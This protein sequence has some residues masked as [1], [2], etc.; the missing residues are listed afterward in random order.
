LFPFIDR[1][2]IE[3][4]TEQITE[5]NKIHITR[6]MTTTD[7]CQLKLTTEMNPVKGEGTKDEEIDKRGRRVIVQAVVS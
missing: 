7:N 2:V 5:K 3:A 1:G 4:K 6:C